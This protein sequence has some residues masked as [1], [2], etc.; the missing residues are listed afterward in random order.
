MF[1]H[2]N[3]Y[4]L[5]C[6]RFIPLSFSDTLPLSIY[7]HWP[8]CKSKCPYCDFNSHVRDNVDQTA[9]LSAY[10]KELHYF[11][12]IIKN[13]P[14][15]SIF[16]GGGTPSLASP[17]VIASI[18]DEIAQHYNLSSD[19]EI[20]MEANPTSIESANFAELAKG[21]V[22]RISIG[23]QSLNS[24]NLKFLGREHSVD[25]S[26][27]A[28][29]IAA[30]H[31]K[32][33]S[34]DFIYALPSQSIDNWLEEL[35]QAH[36]LTNGHMS[37]YQLTIEK[38]TQFYKDFSQKKWM[39]PDDEL[40]A[41][42]YEATGNFLREY[43]MYAYE[44]S[45]YAASGQECKHNLTYWHYDDYIG[46]GAGAHGRYT[47]EGTKY[48][49]QMLH[50]PEEWLAEVQNKGAALQQHYALTDTQAMEEKVMMGLRLKQ[51]ISDYHHLNGGKIA[52]LQQHNL[53]EF[54]DEHLRATNS[55][56]LVLNSVLRYLLSDEN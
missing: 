48:A 1:V 13:R 55:G 46:I 37:L 16:F 12:H 51:G 52:F 2:D 19:T 44:V 45:N 3:D 40:A 17:Y 43:N 53:L 54:H 20:T 5:I 39:L 50:K 15:R 32:R 33:Y 4:Q 49:T 10:I 24:E 38:G 34:L 18:I 21:G 47:L 26:L 41:T 31:F 6:N 30:K 29:E 8:F 14:I 56:R 23:I 42:F 22:N 9:M 27:K 11:R 35:Q 25:E 36:S 28:I 7:I